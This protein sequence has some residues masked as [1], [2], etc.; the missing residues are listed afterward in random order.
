MPAHEATPPVPSDDAHESMHDVEASEADRE[1]GASGPGDGGSGDGGSRDGGSGATGGAAGALC[2]VRQ[3]FR[4]L[5]AGVIV[6]IAAFAAFSGPGGK[7]NDD[8]DGGGG[9]GT[10]TTVEST[11]STT[12]DPGAAPDDGSDPS[13]VTEEPEGP[14]TTLTPPDVDTD[15]PAIDLNVTPPPGDAIEVARWWAATYTAYIGAEPPAE[16]VTRLSGW[17]ERALLDELGALPP[18][19]S[20]DPP[21]QVGGV[22]ALDQPGP[23]G[24]TSGNRHERVSVETEFALVIYD[25]TLVD[26]G[27]TWKVSEA[28]RL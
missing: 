7:G 19:A 28:T 10:T 3:H 24:D 17:T 13:S 2:W 15:R 14:T 26:A 23:A 12:A 20:Y 18:A 21:L 9:S 6:V 1:P 27:G 16:L 22:S 25:L 11:D 5:I 4:G 8:G